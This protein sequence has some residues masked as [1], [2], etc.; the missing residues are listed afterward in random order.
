MNDILLSNEVI[1]YLL[2]EIVLYTLLLISFVVT[3]YIIKNWD[4]SSFTTKQFS[5]ENRSYL[6]ITIISFVIILKIFLLPYFVYTIDELSNIVTGAMCGAGVI[7]SNVYGNP[8]LF[9]KI[10]ILFLSGFW[11]SINRLD[12]KAKNYP[13]TTIKL[14]FFI[15]IFL[16]FT[17]EIYLDISYFTNIESSKPVTCCSIIF[18]E[19]NYL[20]FGLDINKLLIL[21]YLLYF[22][23]FLANISERY[24]LSI[25]SNILFLPIA[26]Y[27]VIYFF[28]TYIYELPT[29]KC[30]FCI[31]Q[32]SYYFI[33]YLLWGLLLFGIFKNIDYSLRRVIF[34]ENIADRDKNISTILL[35]LF[36]L[37]CSGFV[38]NYY[39]KTG[40]FL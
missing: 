8:L 33:G 1:I 6:I 35:T 10:I 4:F 15:F 39:F 7:K 2:S 19:K 30:P 26:Y 20:P 16:L 25:F 24:I 12:L 18:E 3:P 21:F 31:L 14:W 17:L 32:S 37:L 5:L 40:V 28:G 27:S 34:K 38:V 13:Y 29:H 36:V 11:I 9:L 22:L 23:I